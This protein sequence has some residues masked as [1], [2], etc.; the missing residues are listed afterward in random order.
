MRVELKGDIMH[1]QTKLDGLES[2]RLSKLES[3]VQQFKLDQVE[4]DSTIKSN[5]AVIST[6]FLVLQTI[7]YVLFF[8]LIQTV[9]TKV[10]K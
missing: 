3:Q 8:L 5:Q 1:V 6:K 9:F 7:G 4:R 2:G 10:F